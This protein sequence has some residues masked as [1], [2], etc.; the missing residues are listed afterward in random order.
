MALRRPLAG[1]GVSGGKAARA[2]SR[3]QARVGPGPPLGR[4]ARA[5]T[6]GSRQEAGESLSRCGSSLARRLGCPCEAG[7]SREGVAGARRRGA[8]GGSGRAQ[9]RSPVRTPAARLWPVRARE[10]RTH[11][12]PFRG[13][14]GGY[15]GLSSLPFGWLLIASLPAWQDRRGFAA[16]GWMVGADYLQSHSLSSGFL[17]TGSLY[18]N[19]WNIRATLSGSGSRFKCLPI[20]AF[21]IC[22]MG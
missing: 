17:V 13:G 16:R 12:Q 14:I 2:R 21:F 1:G 22:V 5:L 6:V 7:P 19:S 10:P 8:G 20:K 3:A 15:G 18:F 4:S 11:R 9:P